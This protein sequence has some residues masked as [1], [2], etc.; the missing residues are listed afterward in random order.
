LLILFRKLGKSPSRG[1][2]KPERPG[3]PFR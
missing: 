2:R 3:T 1:E